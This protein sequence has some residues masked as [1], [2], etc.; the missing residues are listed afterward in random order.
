MKE[1]F[2][3]PENDRERLTRTEMQSMQWMLNALSSLCYAT[4][5]LDQR[6]GWIPA[7][8]QRMHMLVG[9][10]RSIYKDLQGTVPVRQ[11]RQIKNAADD[12]EVRMVPKMTPQ[13]VTVTLDKE[14][15]MELVDAAQIKC[16]ECI[17]DNEEARECKL[18]KVLETVVP[19]ESYKS[20]LCPYT[21]A[22]W[23]DKP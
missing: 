20:I 8:R 12:L 4:D 21:L 13:K 5:D 17:K 23:E 14:T 10:T 9:M 22:I 6:L 3:L 16:T 18:C 19:L 11:L 1:P 7:G 2:A 15:A